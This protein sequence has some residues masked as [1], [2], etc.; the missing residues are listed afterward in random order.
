MY[1]VARR[2]IERK[3]NEKSKASLW[4]KEEKE[5]RYKGF[6]FCGTGQVNTR[7]Q[8]L[9][10]YVRRT[11]KYGAGP[12]GPALVFL[13]PGEGGGEVPR[14]APQPPIF[15]ILYQGTTTEKKNLV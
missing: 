13:P 3:K 8:Y 2:A 7:Q 14:R 1:R 11:K 10:L 12:A 6:G 9:I 4:K 15:G 5:E